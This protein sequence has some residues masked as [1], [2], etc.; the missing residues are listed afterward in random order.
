MPA[1]LYLRSFWILT[2]LWGIVFVL[3]MVLAYFLSTVPGVIPEGMEYLIFLLPVVFAF[4]IVGFQFLISPWIMDITISWVYQ[5]TKYQVDEL[6]THI[7]NFLY[8]QM[9]LHNFS[10]KLNLF[11]PIKLK[12]MGYVGKNN[13][14]KIALNNTKT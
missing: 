3:A 14:I 2:F 7:R 9:E 11:S 6:P 4:I 10:L 13:I 1:R 12:K 5:A 8:Q